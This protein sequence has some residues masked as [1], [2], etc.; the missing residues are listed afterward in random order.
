MGCWAKWGFVP[1]ARHHVL[2]TGER[3]T[4]GVSWNVMSQSN[5]F[6]LVWIIGADSSRMPAWSSARTGSAFSYVSRASGHGQ[7][8]PATPSKPLA[9]PCALERGAHVGGP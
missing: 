6:R 3:R 9:K 7:A 5:T 2:P 4:A 1:F 8:D